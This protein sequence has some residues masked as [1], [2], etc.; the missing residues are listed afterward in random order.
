M[1]SLTRQT[2]RAGV[3]PYPHQAA[4]FLNNPLRR[5]SGDDDRAVKQLDLTGFE[6]VLEVG[7]GPGYFSVAISQK[8]TRG[9]LDLLDSRLEMLDKSRSA[10]DRAE[11]Y[12]VS[13]HQGDAE[14]EL[15]FYDDS[16]DVAFLASVLGEISNRQG[17][18]RSLHRIVKPGGLLVFREGFPDPQRLSVAELRALAE[19]E[20][21]V[22][23]DATGN[24]WHDIV[25]FRR[26]P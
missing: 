24:R 21:F 6:R 1:D 15:P 16:F 25:R 22:F 11:C 20:G 7:P 4:Y 14:D 19:S 10:L 12:N 18:V 2:R 9:R 8:L 5:M 17:C 3:L 13:F 23:C 26:R